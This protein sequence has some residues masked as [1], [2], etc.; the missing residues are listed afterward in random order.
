MKIFLT[1]DP[2]DRHNL[3]VLFAAGLVYWSG[4]TTLLPTLPSYVQDIGGTTQQVGMVMGAF[5]IGLLLFRPWLGK[6]VDGQSRK[7]VLLLG[8]VVAAIAP[9]GYL[10]VHSIPL[11]IAVRAFHGIS[12]AAFTTAYSTLVV[13]LS[14]LAVRGELVGYMS[15]VQPIGVAMG[16]AVGGLLQ[17]AAGYPPLFLLASGLGIL[18]TLG[19]YQIADSRIGANFTDNPPGKPIISQNSPL[20]EKQREITQP[21]NQFW[22]LLLSPRLL[23]PALVMLLMGLAFGALSTFVPLYIRETK[24]NLNAGWFYTAAAIASFSLRLFIGRASDRF[25][26]GLFITGS[27]ACYAI[28]ML[29]LSRANSAGAFL[30]AGLVEGA[31]GGTLFPMMIALIADRSFPHERGRIFALCVGGFDLGMAI[32]GPV[33]G[34][35][36]PQLGYRGIFTLSTGLAFLALLVFLTQSSQNLSHSLKFALG[37]ESDRYALE[38]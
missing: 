38:K 28:A 14:P 26:R 18:S 27:L 33:L 36:A 20:S 3:L 37:R 29:I 24:V 13:D 1:L 7:G 19:A 11:L 17:A 35:F 22:Q 34:S 12:I 9:L 21:S 8:T 31:G 30:L 4:I 5:A 2:S 15:L 25:G 6:M 23:I 32:A 10:F 16:P